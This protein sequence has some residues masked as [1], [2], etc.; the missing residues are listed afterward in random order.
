MLPAFQDIGHWFSPLCFLISLLLMKDTHWLLANALVYLLRYLTILTSWIITTWAVY[1]WHSRR[2][3]RFDIFS[4][5]C[6]THRIWASR[7]TIF[8]T[9]LIIS[10]ACIY[11]AS[12][13]EL[14][15]ASSQADDIAIFRFDRL[16][17]DEPYAFLRERA[18]QHDVIV[19]CFIL[20]DKFFD[21]LKNNLMLAGLV[22]RDF[23]DIC[24]RYL[25]RHASLATRHSTDDTLTGLP[26][27]LKQSDMIFS[28]SSSTTHYL[29]YI[30]II[31]FSPSILYFDDSY[32][33]VRLP[34]S[35]SA[36]VARLTGARRASRLP[37]ATH[38]TATFSI[39]LATS[40]LLFPLYLGKYIY[41]ARY[42]FTYS[43]YTDIE[44]GLHSHEG[45]TPYRKFTTT[46]TSRHFRWWPKEYLFE[47]QGIT[48]YIIT[49]LFSFMLM[50]ISR[51]IT[52]VYILLLLISLALFIFSHDY[53][54]RL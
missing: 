4:R 43:A 12:L 51:W 13:P 53:E 11:D 27:G 14:R 30:S 48:Y 15:K 2:L 10:A 38:I 41:V 31:I 40:L 46:L 16:V 34:S 37:A 5:W 3:I 7:F 50:S 22:F 17:F 18:E 24:H 8:N 44:V 54:R 45:A 42:Y 35:P 19:D 52:S 20:F 25:W 1:I 33:V 36:A 49:G 9:L 29:P 47:C 28:S 26:Y 21:I 6:C 23:F 39:F 32:D